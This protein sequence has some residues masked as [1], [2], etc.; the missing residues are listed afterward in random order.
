MIGEGQKTTGGGWNVG[1]D[2]NCRE[3]ITWHKTQQNAWQTD[4]MAASKY[5]GNM[6]SQHQISTSWQ[7]RSTYLHTRPC[8]V[9]G[10]E[11][12]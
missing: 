5:N 11:N 8:D 9:T 4:N 1:C 12:G 6:T 10:W 2:L 3:Q 7:G